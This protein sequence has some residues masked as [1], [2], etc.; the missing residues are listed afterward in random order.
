MEGLRLAGTLRTALPLDWTM[1]K[2]A[3]CWVM[4]GGW[5]VVGLMFSACFFV[6]DPARV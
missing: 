3:L 6:S 4:G 5:R 2:E 1:V